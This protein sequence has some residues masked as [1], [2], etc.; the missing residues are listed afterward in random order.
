[1]PGVKFIAVMVP[2][3]WFK[4]K[5]HEMCEVTPFLKFAQILFR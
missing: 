5:I 1:M 3:I 4:T 2:K